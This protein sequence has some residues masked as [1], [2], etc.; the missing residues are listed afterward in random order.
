MGRQQDG[1]PLAPCPGAWPGV[2]S[3]EETTTMAERRDEI[4]DTIRQRIISGLHLGTL[5]PG[6]RLPSTREI[7]EEFGV[8]PRTVMAAYRLLEAEGLVDT[9]RGRGGVRVRHPEP[10]HASR[11]LAQLIT[12]S[13]ATWRDLFEF[14]KLVEPAAAARAAAHATDEQRA[15][16]V[17]L[18]ERGIGV[19][20][21][22]H[23]EF[24]TLLA[25]ISGN[26]ILV[27]VLEGVAQAIRAQ[28]QSEEEAGRF[29]L[30]AAAESHRKIAQSVAA[31]DARRAEK[32]MRDHIEAFQTEVDGFNALDLPLIPNS[33]WRGAS[34]FA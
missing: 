15:A 7:A 1:T 26:P 3:Q 31:G 33:H 14:R 2:P 34:P 19:H 9:R 29:D 27:M 6:A 10:G 22:A 4:A 12:L 25:Q 24:H 20:G 5:R 30:D 23:D 16:L 13:G 17:A 32:R 8:A 28:Q 21:A 11:T 18:A